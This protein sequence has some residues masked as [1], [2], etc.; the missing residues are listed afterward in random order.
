ML[1]R[2]EDAGNSSERGDFGQRCSSFLMRETRI[3]CHLKKDRR[4]KGNIEGN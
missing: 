2:R 1:K 4:G 3:I